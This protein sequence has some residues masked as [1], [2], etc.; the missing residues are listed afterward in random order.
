MET[1]FEIFNIMIT[2]EDMLDMQIFYDDYRKAKIAF[3]KMTKF[4]ALSID[5]NVSK[6][7]E[8]CYGISLQN[9]CESIDIS[10]KKTKSVDEMMNLFFSYMMNGHLQFSI[11]IMRGF[12]NLDE[13]KTSKIIR[14][15]QDRM[16][17]DE[18]M[19]I[20]KDGL[21]SDD[22]KRIAIKICDPFLDGLMGTEYIKKWS[23]V[24]NGR[25]YGI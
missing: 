12:F 17:R 20:A 7:L 23:G 18:M 13:E 10:L 9:F 24:R 22:W 1:K 2:L 4:D 3:K 8:S 21:V 15:V 25:D 6:I 14:N 19:L 16:S 5:S 11:K